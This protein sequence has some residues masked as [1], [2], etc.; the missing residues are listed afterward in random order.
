[1]NTLMHIATPRQMPLHN[2][3]QAIITIK[4]QKPSAILL[5][6]FNS[7]PMKPVLSFSRSST[8]F[9]HWPPSSCPQILP[10]M[11]DTKSP[12]PNIHR[13]TPDIKSPT[14]LHRSFS[15]L[16]AP[17]Q[18]ISSSHALL[19]SFSLGTKPTGGFLDYS[20]A[21][22]RTWIDCESMMSEMSPLLSGACLHQSMRGYVSIR[23][24]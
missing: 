10:Y 6:A 3:R 19:V 13:C 18:L 8:S 17:P 4:K 12:P 24:G 16:R 22:E 23:H 15:S 5:T 14:L 20:R 11:T 9:S 1:M 7:S 2:P 21:K